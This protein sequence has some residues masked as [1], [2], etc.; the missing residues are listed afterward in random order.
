M[1]TEDL[2]LDRTRGKT[3]EILPKNSQPLPS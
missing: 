1:I 2:F 3:E